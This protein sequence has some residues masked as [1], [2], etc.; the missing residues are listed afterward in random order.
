MPFDVD[1]HNIPARYDANGELI[2]DAHEHHDIRFLMIAHSDDNISVS[3]ESHDVA[4][5][6]P[7]EVLERTNEESIVRMLRKAVE[8]LG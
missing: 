4:W 8:L 2:E 6:T 3:D 7:D 1:V 5:F